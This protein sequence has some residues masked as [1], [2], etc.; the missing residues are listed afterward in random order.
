MMSMYQALTVLKA[1]DPRLEL[2]AQY[3]FKQT[4]QAI[5]AWPTIFIS[6]NNPLE[7]P[8]GFEETFDWLWEGVTLNEH[9][10]NLIYGTKA[11]DMLCRLISA[12][13]IYPDGSYNLTFIDLIEQKK[14]EAIYGN[15]K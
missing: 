8:H 4:L 14:H 10:L 5:T 12:Y 9:R 7:C 2:V 6:W 3:S 11:I 15:R 1:K 13:L